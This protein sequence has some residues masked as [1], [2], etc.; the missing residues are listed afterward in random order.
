MA[1]RHCRHCAGPPPGSPDCCIFD[2]TNL[3][4]ARVAARVQVGPRAQGYLPPL[5]LGEEGPAPALHHC[6]GLTPAAL[7][8]RGHRLRPRLPLRHGCR[9]A[10]KVHEAQAGVWQCLGRCQDSYDEGEETDR[11]GAETELV[12]QG[13]DAGQKEPPQDPGWEGDDQVHCTVSSEHIHEHWPD[14]CTLLCK[15]LIFMIRCMITALLCV[16]VHDQEHVHCTVPCTSL[17]PGTCKLQVHCCV[18]RW[19]GSHTLHC[20]VRGPHS[21]QS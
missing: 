10:H 12:L 20:P 7:L 8:A 13:L 9:L 18:C 21:Y 17:W 15:V 14:T 16:Q 2:F 4:A 1:W 6:G 5:L 3:Y 11:C 19:P